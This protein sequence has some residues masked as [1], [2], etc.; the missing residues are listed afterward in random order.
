MARTIWRTARKRHRC[1]SRTYDC[2]G[3]IEP[4]DRYRHTTGFPGEDGLDGYERPVAWKEC[5]TCSK[6]YGREEVSRG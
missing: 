1:D 2:P 6:L 3:W 5:G 4:G